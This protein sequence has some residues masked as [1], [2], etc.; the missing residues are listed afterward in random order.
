MNPFIIFCLIFSLIWTGLCLAD[1]P[2]S[3]DKTPQAPVQDTSTNDIP[4]KAD[5][6]PTTPAIDVS[7]SNKGAEIEP[8]FQLEFEPDAYYTSLDLYIDLLKEPMLNLDERDEIDIYKYLILNSYLPKFMLVEA[9]IY[10]MPVLG[11]AI[12]KYYIDF[13]NNSYI[14]GNTN[15]AQAV[16]AGFEEPFAFSFFFGNIVEFNK[17]EQNVRVKNKGY[18]G[19]LLSSGF[20]Q[21][22]NNELIDD[23]WYEFEFK[24]KGEKKES[25]STLSWS[26]RIG[27][28][29]HTNVEIRDSIYLSMRRD[30]LDFNEP[31]YLL[32]KN[33]GFEYYFAFSR[34][35][36]PLGHH[37]YV[38]KK[39][40]LPGIKS[41]IILEIGFI[42][43][44]GKKYMGALFD[45]SNKDSYSLVIR[46]NIVF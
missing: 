25:D 39:I 17:D 41:T 28:K 22:R 3:S 33:S 46:P 27:T 6:T 7:E 45:S 21:I 11:I 12:K 19:Y 13:Y 35:F 34:E 23:N 4:K 5:E 40:P 42:Y 20:Y 14:I 1:S 10:P 32:L 43:D 2:A 18:M 38:D 36:I 37:F 26:Y 8:N 24:L 31:F 30:N 16:T 29:L 44:S 15:I 9:S